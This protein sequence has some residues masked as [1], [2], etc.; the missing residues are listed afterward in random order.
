MK[1]SVSPDRSVAYEPPQQGLERRRFC[2]GQCTQM[3]FSADRIVSLRY[4]MLSD[5]SGIYSVVCCFE[6]FRLS[7]R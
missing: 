6:Y 4:S 1:T 7:R 5:F 2:T 3:F